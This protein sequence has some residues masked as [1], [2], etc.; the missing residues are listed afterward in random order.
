[1]GGEQSGHIVLR[2]YLDIGDG[3]FTALRI[4]ETIYQTNNLDMISFKKCPQI[5]INLPVAVKKDLTAEPLASII[6]ESKA[7]LHAGRIIVRYSG[8]E[9]LLR[10]M[11]EDDS[12]DH[13][14]QI[15]NLLAQT[16]HKTLS[17]P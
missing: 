13:A 2:D 11:V 4:L 7:Q 9:N 1:M 6:E 14:Q 8:T 16:L 15:A 17:T 3:I 5:S 12:H 10:V